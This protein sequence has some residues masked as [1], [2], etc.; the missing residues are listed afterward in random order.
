[1]IKIN[2]KTELDKLWQVLPKRKKEKREQDVLFCRLGI[3]QDKESLQAIGNR[4]H[5]TRERIRQIQNQGIKGLRKAA[6]NNS[7][8]F[9]EIAAEVKKNGGILSLPTANKLFLSPNNNDDQTKKL[10]HLFLIANPNLNYFKASS[11][12]NPFFTYKINSKKFKQIVQKINSYFKDKDIGEQIEN[13]AQKLNISVSILREISQIHKDFGLKDENIGLKIF[14]NINPRTT[15]NKI[16]YIF[17]KHNKPLHFSEIARL[18]K[19]EQLEKK[20]PTTPTI[21]NEL[22]KHRDKYVLIG[23]GTYALTK[24]G[25]A[26]GTVKEVARNIIAN[27]KKKLTREELITAILEQRQVKRNTI[28]LNISSF[29]KQLSQ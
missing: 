25:Y 19:K 9:E 22:I 13:I 21:H 29:K 1:M 10:L 2:P 17:N 15:E 16:D 28:I 7:K 24:W 23:R 4:Y 27:S 8:I 18:I 3:K 12:T 5:I 26:P 20:L 11:T 14:A 6:K